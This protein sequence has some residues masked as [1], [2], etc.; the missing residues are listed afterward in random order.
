LSDK[1]ATEAALH[2]D[3]FTGMAWRQ[4]LAAA[5]AI[6]HPLMPEDAS[7]SARRLLAHALKTD[8]LDLLKGPAR[9]LSQ[10]E[11]TVFAGCLSRR[12]ASEP[13]SRIV[14]L[15]GFFGRD[16]L[17]TPD[18]LDPRPDSETVIDAALARVRPEW[19]DGDGLE[20]LDIG[21][22][23]GCLLL[24]LLAE[25]PAARGVGIDPSAATLATAAANAERLR[26]AAR[27]SFRRGR[28]A[29]LAVQLGRRFALIV[30]NPPYIPGEEI[31]ALDRDVRDFDP[32]LAL[33]GGPDGLAVYREIA[34]NLAFVAH[35]GWLALEIG[36][37]QE[38]QV[39]EIF[40][41]YS[42]G[43]HLDWVDT[44]RDMAGKQRCVIFRL[45]H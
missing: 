37:G 4:A 26:V 2:A 40:K 8:W 38:N 41:Q 19:K 13:V 17:I 14:G 5:I 32:R 35:N 34:Q 24:T 42:T 6:L 11:A 39:L 43:L 7:A 31:D 30:S 3:S 1:M 20:I 21:T 27:T 23:T 44:A 25:L 16:F 28:F 15:R 9:T 10:D 33:D 45:S 18:T 36:A 29:D 22:G 12:L